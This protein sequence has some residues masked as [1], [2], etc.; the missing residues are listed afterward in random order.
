M[1]LTLAFA[2]KAKECLFIFVDEFCPPYFNK[3]NRQSI[4]KVQ[5]VPHL[6]VHAAIPSNPHMNMSNPKLASPEFTLRKA[7]QM[8]PLVQSITNDIVKLTDD[9]QQTRERLECLKDIRVGRDA[10][11]VYRAEVKSIE[12]VVTQKSEIVGGYIGELTELELRVHRVTEGFV[13][14]PARRQ[15]KLVCLCWKLGET[16]VKYWHAADEKCEQRRLVDL[17]I[18]RQSGDHAFV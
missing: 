16:D 17:E 13:D 9:V 3:F 4:I 11:D 8:L 14:F 2:K 6:S 18:I 1:A 5:Q 15:N 12:K 10:P 7:N